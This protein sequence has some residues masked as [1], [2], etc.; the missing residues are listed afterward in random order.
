M[1]KIL[2]DTVKQLA[3]RG[4]PAKSQWPIAVAAAQRAGN[5]KAGSLKPTAQGVK[6]GKMTQAQRRKSPP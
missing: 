2:E 4:V 1:P 5:L 6:R 3:L